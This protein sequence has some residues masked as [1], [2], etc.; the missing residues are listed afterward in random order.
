MSNASSKENIYEMETE[1]LVTINIKNGKGV[2]DLQ[3][4]KYQENEKY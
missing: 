1:N 2:G 3:Q 4:L